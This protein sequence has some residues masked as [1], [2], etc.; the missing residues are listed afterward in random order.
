MSLIQYF[1]DI[2]CKN[3]TVIRWMENTEI[4]TPGVYV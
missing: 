1:H 3:K 2:F 4:F